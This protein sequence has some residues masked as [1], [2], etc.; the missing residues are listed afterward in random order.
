MIF[1]KTADK[2]NVVPAGLTLPFILI[3]SLF[4]W[5][6]LANNMT[7]PLV[8]AF[9]RIF[10]MSNLQSALVQFSFYG[11]Y[12]ALALPAA[13]V[14]KRYSY[15]TGVLVGLGLFILGA[16]LFYPASQLFMYGPFLVAIFILAGGLSILETSC[17]PYIIALGPEST[18]TRRLNL[19]QSFNPVGSVMGMMLAGFFILPKLNPVT[20]QQRLSMAADALREVQ[21]AELTAVMGPYVGTALVLVLLW[22]AIAVTRMPRASDA[23]PAI[24]FGPT[25]RRLMANKHYLFG[26]IAQF[27]YVAAQICVWTF[28]IHYISAIASNGGEQTLLRVLEKTGI[29][30]FVRYIRLI[31]PTK[32][33]SPETI[34]GIYHI[35][36]MLTFLIS[37]FICTA[38]MRYVRP[39]LMLT[40]LAGLAFILCLAV[41]FF[42]GLMGVFSLILISA[43]MSLMFPTIYGIALN[44]L[45]D[46]TKFG[47]A[48]LVMAILG[49]ALFPLLQAN[50]IDVWGPVNGPAW[51]YV[52]PLF[53]FF[54]VGVYGFFDIISTR[55]P[56]AVVVN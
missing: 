42:P 23:S 30:K 49:G 40:A 11:A 27:F 45:G 17:N 36:A 50:L 12:F 29:N 22:V 9:S 3:T 48:G 15:K 38:L 44:G 55:K 37:R 4:A 39:S 19:A 41:I 32:A 43:C 24:N 20:D 33:M 7:D 2:T 54:I 28:T 51:S 16:L 52:V 1:K 53:C 31:D 25:I 21:K 14:I 8:K 56:H 47:G 10:T 5:W 26:V 34:A 46:D 18:A 6:G 35:C 13:F